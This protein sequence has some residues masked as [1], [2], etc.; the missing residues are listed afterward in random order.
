MP[1]FPGFIGG[2]Y[3]SQSPIVDQERLVNW[4]VEDQG[5]EGA[6]ARRVFYPTPGVESFATPSSPD[7]GRANFS[8]LET[9]LGRAFCVIGNTFYEYDSDG[10]LTS[11]GTVAVDANPATI[12]TNGSATGEIFITSGDKGYIFTLSTNAFA[13]VLSSGATMGAMLYGYFL[14]FDFDGQQFVISDLFDGLTWDATQFAA[15]TIGSDPWQ[16]MHTTPY[17]YI[18]LAG[19]KSSEFWY[20]SGAFPFPFAVDPSGFV[21][22]GA[23]SHFG[24]VQVA[25]ASAWLARLPGGGYEVVEATGFSPRTIST[26]ALEH[27]INQYDAVDDCIASTYSEE[28]HVFLILTFPTAGISHVYD[29]TTRLWHDRGTWISSTASFTFWQPVFH[30][31]AFEKHLFLDRSSGTMYHASNAFTLDV[32]SRPLRRVRRSP[33]IT[34]DRQWVF[35]NKF[36][37]LL[38]TGEIGRAHV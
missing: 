28:G 14:A 20:N 19:T 2:S 9:S 13:T 29:R 21:S 18:L 1:A 33:A 27:R 3:R 32:D 12:C 38:E 25:E 31:F 30:A 4:Y 23:A 35:H 34:D 24:V 11:R 37:L 8:D 16:T 17:G 6:T 26:R 22:K 5:S 36:E 7:A 15:R 10:I